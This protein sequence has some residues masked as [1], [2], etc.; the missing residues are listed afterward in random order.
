[1]PSIQALVA[2]ALT[3]L[4]A[5]TAL[6]PGLAAATTQIGPGQSFALGGEQANPVQLEGRNNGAVAV[7]L[8]RRRGT[9]APVLILRAEPG[10]GF[11][12]TLP[13]GTTALARNTSA[14]QPARV[15]FVFN[16]Q[17]DRLSMRYE[18]ASR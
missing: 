14:S 12:T 5:L 17:I 1:M 9:E 16:G 7:E 8:L 6:L 11:S 10:Q 18:P 3:A 15:R 4:T 2:I 13:A